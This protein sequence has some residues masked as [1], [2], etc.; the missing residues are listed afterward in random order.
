MLRMLT[1]SKMML[2]AIMRTDLLEEDRYALQFRST[3]LIA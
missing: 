3:G 2:R 1:L